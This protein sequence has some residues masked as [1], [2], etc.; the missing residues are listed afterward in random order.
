MEPALSL[1]YSS[2]SGDGVAGM[3]WSLSGLSAI[4]RC[5]QTPEQDDSTSASYAPGITYTNNDRLCL[6]GQRLVKVNAGAYG[7]S[8]SEYRTEIDSYARITQ[9]GGDLSG[10]TTC[11]RVERKDGR[12]LHYGAVT[13][14]SPLPTS[15]V[16]STAHARV[17]PASASATLSWQVERIEDR[18][19]NNQLYTYADFGSGEVLLQ[20]VTYTGYTPT[21]AVGDRT[22]TFA[23]TPRTSAAN[24]VTDMSS[25]YLAGGLS[26]QTQA[27]ASI[28][29]AVGGTTVRTYTPT[30]AVAGHAGETWGYAG[31]LLMTKLQECATNAAST[32]CHPATKLLY[33]DGPLNFPVKSL[34]GFGLPMDISSINP[35]RINTIGDLD[36]DGTR[37]AAAFVGTRKFLVQLT[38]DRQL[39]SAL[40]LTGTSF[41]VLPECYADIDGSGRAAMLALPASAGAP[42]VV[43]F[44]A[45]NYGAFARGAIA[46][47][48]PF[49]T[50]SSNIAYAFAVS[51]AAKTGDFNGDGRVDVAVIGPHAFCGSDAFGTKRGVFIWLNAMTGPL[52]SGQTAQFTPAAGTV[53]AP[54]PVLCLPRMA[55]GGPNYIEPA[56]DHVADFDGNGLADLFL[57]YQGNGT[58]AGNIVGVARFQKNGAGITAA[59]QNC[60][61]IGLTADECDGS[62]H[63]VT[64]WMDVNGDGLDDFVIARPTTQQWQLKL[65]RGSGTLGTII[66]PTGNVSAGLVRY[67]VGPGSTK[68]FRYTGR[69]P[70]MD[71]D[72]DGKPDL[73]TPSTTQGLHGFALKMCTINKVDP[74]PNAEGCPFASGAAP[75]GV[76]DPD[77]P[78]AATCAAYA[79]PEDPDGVNVTLPANSNQ[80]GP[81]Y[82]FQWNGLPAF[83]AYSG[84]LVHG[85]PSDNSVYHL[86]MLKFVQTGANAF[87]I[88]LVETPLVSRLG[89]VSAAHADDLFGDGLADLVTAVGCANFIISN[90]NPGDNGYWSYPACSVVGDGTYGPTTFPDGTPNAAFGT[91]VVGYGSL[92]QGVAALGGSP[93][94]PFAI[95][96][97]PQ[98]EI[99]Q[100]APATPI[101]PPPI[102]AGL[103]DGVTNGIG[104]WTSWGYAPLAVP[105][106]NADLAMYTVPPTNGYIDK[107]HFYFQSSMPVV[108]GMA[109]DS[110]TGDIFN[111]RSAYYGYTEAIYHPFGR[112]F[113]GFR[114]ITAASVTHDADDPTQ[115]RTTT[116]YNQKF[117]LTGKVEKVET[118]TPTNGILV[119]RE[120]D[121]WRCGRQGRTACAQGDA[122]VTP[123]GTTVQQPFLDEQLVQVFDLATGSASYHIDTVNA[124]TAGTSGWD[125]TA[126][127]T[128]TGV[129][130]NLNDQV[131]TAVDDTSGGTFITSHT[132]TTTSCYDLTG[133]GSWWVDQRLGTLVTRSVA[134]A[135]SHAL[136]AGASAPAQTVTTSYTWNPNRTPAT[137]TVQPGIANQ[138]STTTWTYLGT[139][140]GLPSQVSVNA[141]DLTAL[142]SPTRT[143]SY[144]Y[145]KD[146]TNASGD[147]YFVLTTKNGLNQTT[148]TTHDPRDGQVLKTTDPNGVQVVVMNDPFGRAIDIEHLGS[149]NL[150]F[151]PGILGAWESCRNA[152]G[153][154]GQCPVNNGHDN[155]ETYAS[156]RVTTAQAGYPTKVGWYDDLSRPIKQAERGFSGAY[157]ATLTDYA[158][159]G[160]IEQQ[161]TPYTV[162][163]TAPF[164]TAFEYDA[165]RRPTLKLAHVDIGGN[166]Y[167]QS[168][169]TY[170][171]RKTTTTVHDQVV[172]LTPNGTC[173]TNATPCL[174]TSRA[175]NAL[176]ELMQ[177]TESPILNGVATTLST[178]K[179]TEPQGHVV[180]IT[181]AE[182][183]L[184]TASYNALGQRTASSDPDQGAW[185]FTYDAFG[186]LLVRTDARSVVT[187]V[188]KRDVLGRTTEQQAV[189]P[190]SPPP[191]LAN[192]TIVDRW[193]FDPA[194]GIG[195]LG[196]MQRLRGPN[197]TTPSANPE[198]WKEVY[199][200][201]ALTARPSTITTT[202]SEGA[203]QT[204]NTAMDYD[205]DGRPNTHTYPSPNGA[206][207]LQV[208]RSYTSFGQF[209]SLSN[210]TTNQVYWTANAE[211]EWGHIVS[212]SWL[213]NALT[214]THADYDSTGQAKQKSWF[215]GGASDQFD[216]QYNRLGNLTSQARS[217]AG[218]NV[219]ENY[220]YDPLQRLMSRSGS[221]GSA[222]YA[223]T[224]SGNLTEKSDFGVGAN[225]Y[226]YPAGKHGVTSIALP[227]GLTATYSYDAN[228]NLVGGNTIN[229]I[230]DAES[231]L[232]TINRAYLLSGPG[233]KIFCNGFD[234]GTN[235]CTNPPGGGTTTWTYG[236]DGERSTEQSNQ[237]QGLRY[238]GPDG[239]E[240]IAATG[241]SKHELGPVLV[242]RTGG[243]DS[244]TVVLRDRLGS[245]VTVLDGASAT[246]R[247]YDAFGAARNGDM[248]PRHNGTLNL[249]D[250]IHGFTHHTHADDV[251][252]IF[253]RGRVYDPA[254]GRFLSVDPIVGNR[255]DSQ[256]LNPY[257]YL[258]NRPFS[259]TDPTGYEA[260]TGSH[261]DRQD[262]S[263]CSNQGVSGGG[264]NSPSQQQQLQALAAK[265][266]NIGASHWN[267]RN[268]ADT[269][270]PKGAQSKP[271][272]GQSSDIG[273]KSGTVASITTLDTVTVRPG[274]D[275][276][277][278]QD[279][280]WPIYGAEHEDW[281][282]RQAWRIQY[283]M[284]GGF[285]DYQWELFKSQF[286]GD[287][288]AAAMGGPASV[289][290]TSAEVQALTDTSRG[291]TNAAKV[292]SSER[293]ALIDMARTDKRSGLSRED[294]RA[295]Q[296]LNRELPDPF[297]AE[298]VRIDKGHLYGAPHT[299]LPHGHVG[300]VDHIPIVDPEP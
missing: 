56:M 275:W 268:G 53:G 147:G 100:S 31:R 247:S 63:Y 282:D 94:E 269:Q 298:M 165:L 15:C 68:A 40:E 183:V 190:A 170:A 150:P 299:R 260:C 102:L 239:Y 69:L 188:N 87:R 244:I 252:L 41:C 262:G 46:T 65:N 292:F 266:V 144:I 117:P 126:C 26:L 49:F 173:P 61:V 140:Y 103:L 257:S 264:A 98:P 152:Q 276:V 284:I 218:A 122:L 285:Y 179:W 236:T 1:D 200:Y 142:L 171:G 253:M 20:K 25:S 4:H 89:D 96:H 67:D 256:V 145:T 55:T 45:W 249:A 286:E 202:I 288:P 7:L 71:V 181:D 85:T 83:T 141:P 182:G 151:E 186:E 146:G 223:Y 37:E 195:E 251:G 176:G 287:A 198:V 248:T 178:N 95:D 215:G 64:Q 108:W 191:G 6:D 125:N 168:D 207:R 32:A 206:N 237:S 157:N 204:L 174:Q 187:A 203:V 161:S 197:R 225:A 277:M 254:I 274:Q 217:A 119:H 16:A 92:N 34:S 291:S 101:L 116:T 219:S 127:D 229:A 230:Y 72:G 227:Q 30:Y 133:S 175:T 79:C 115:L 154:L 265:I 199:G 42:Q 184:T 81:G 156:F 82:N 121:T 222:A 169:I 149:T 8:G 172:A 78:D 192:E 208:K 80:P 243:A 164:F 128:G 135:G 112:G 17:Q 267:T 231:K 109:K 29:T 167:Q 233:D 293:Q 120:T 76:P 278:S 159:N 261:I 283:G 271:L 194:N 93:G 177:T 280:T 153:T 113:Q 213:N 166:G 36:G 226:A 14:G 240:L 232:R 210:A 235:N 58:G 160:E 131:V 221:S 138:R 18:V 106:E 110:G 66:T 10:A 19:G 228:G 35:V 124:A 104:D 242:T 155:N 28:T 212:E 24:G 134:Y 148:T 294:M 54:L 12:I 51:T 129:F 296:Q 289:L 90:G 270:I 74:Y 143:T 136:P 48:N 196:Q 180:A 209:A 185:T 43:S 250:T 50:A 234:D 295:Y 44:S 272:S 52:T 33:N 11:F 279:A 62:Q 158:P 84:A 201:E 86:A 238:F 290:R 60:A 189:P 132:T 214:G 130:G 163:Q 57:V 21:N 297:P 241:T 216:Y 111:T 193:G 59:I 137:Q 70:V 245:P 281:L 97:L 91:N 39:H 22:V 259:G 3:G 75:A 118:T 114:T 38:G 5:P 211:N 23:W 258:A 27:L 246:L 47:S 88:D 73:L 263:P 255:R 107:R 139:S 300:P 224:K 77:A 13:V 99:R 105:V 2:R 162:G 273:S 9:T 220:T 205:I 123:T